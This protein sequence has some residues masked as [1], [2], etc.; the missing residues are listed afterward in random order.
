METIYEQVM[1][2]MA[3]D[4]LR[5]RLQPGAPLPP[6]EVLMIRYRAARATIDRALFLL[7]KEDLILVSAEGPVVNE[8]P[9]PRVRAAERKVR[10]EAQKLFEEARANGLDDHRT[11][12][13][14]L[15]EGGYDGAK[16]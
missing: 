4:I 11:I 1:D 13:I 14:I 9:I 15:E 6:S 12:R 10:Q 5:G 2:R 3:E 16:G 8:D 7:E